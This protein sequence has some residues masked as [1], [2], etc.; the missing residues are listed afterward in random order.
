MTRRQR[1]RLL[2]LF[3]FVLLPL[4]V[5]GGLWIYLASGGLERRVEQEWAKI[6]PGK[7]TL[8]RIKVHG[9]DQV[10]VTKIKVLG[11]QGQQEFCSASSITMWGS[12][13]QRR[14]QR[15]ALRGLEGTL[16]AQNLSFL[17]ALINSGASHTGDMPKG[18][19]AN[20]L[21]IEVLDSRLMLP[22]ALAVEL[23]RLEIQRD[24]G[25]LSLTSRWKW[26]GQPFSVRATASITQT[27]VRVDVIEGEG[28]PLPIR[29]SVMVLSELGS[30]LPVPSSLLPPE[31]RLE[32]FK[33]V[34][35]GPAI[36][37]S[38]V[39][40]FDTPWCGIRS[41]DVS[42]CWNEGRISGGSLGLVLVSK[43]AN[44]QEK[45]QERFRLDFQ[46]EN[47]GGKDAKLV[48]IPREV[49]PLK[50]LF[51]RA[52]EAKLIAEPSVFVSQY[53]PQTMDLEGTR[54][55]LRGANAEVDA[56][57]KLKTSVVRFEAQPV[58]EIQGQLLRSADRW[59]INKLSVTAKLTLVFLFPLEIQLEGSGVVSERG[60]QS[61]YFAWTKLAIPYLE[62]PMVAPL[63]HQKKAIYDD[64]KSRF[65]RGEFRWTDLSR[66]DTYS[67]VVMGAENARLELTKKGECLRLQGNNLDARMANL[68][69]PPVQIRRGKVERLDATFDLAS[70]RSGPLSLSA[71]IAELEMQHAMG[72]VAPA[73]LVVNIAGE[74][75]GY[76]AEIRLPELPGQACILHGTGLFSSLDR[77]ELVNLEITPWRNAL[78][79]QGATLG[80]IATYLSD[81][82]GSIH[83]SLLLSQ[84]GTLLATERMQVQ[85]LQYSKVCSGIAG[86]LRAALRVLPDGSYGLDVFAFFGEGTIFIDPKHRISFAQDP[87]CLEAQVQWNS[88][89]IRLP[90]LLLRLAKTDGVPV[91]DGWSLHAEGKVQQDLR[92]GNLEV[93]A[94]RVD[95]PW[96]MK[97]VPE[98]APGSGITMTG[99]GSGVIALS[100]LAGQEWL[101]T[102]AV[103]EQHADMVF[104]NFSVKGLAG[105]LKIEPRILNLDGSW[106]VPSKEEME[107]IPKTWTQR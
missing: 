50:A 38:A 106:R 27:G 5:G 103:A 28:L 3:V 83:G 29:D 23:E 1:L 56:T 45:S 99:R 60:T 58:L 2:A 19:F 53:I 35:L 64:L 4:L 62:K 61:G 39:C 93:V 11:V 14:L 20:D 40:R 26:K 76:R 72:S 30:P 46:G 42:L 68:F 16:S 63:L 57:V 48:L 43:D 101:L 32:R 80:Q 25:A 91:P 33:A 73:R 54:I 52:V 9:L 86:N 13:R 59:N 94:D 96:L 105:W 49:W 100:Y 71:T 47:I 70:F 24:G 66:L 92:G 51:E 104:P 107:R 97:H 95:L 69:A 84:P 89:N 55:E 79:M 15:V 21:Q 8:G 102:G 85:S 81:W 74:G 17:R 67:M 6:L 90:R 44:A 22:G 87:S 98:F 65:P 78:R 36:N 75:A 10:E 31:G 82:S 7:L 88:A 77:L 18:E 41:A 12:V 37:A 34:T